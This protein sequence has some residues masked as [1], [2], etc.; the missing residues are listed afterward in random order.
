MI[1]PW[2]PDLNWNTPAGE[3]LNALLHVLP[4]DQPIQITVFGSAPLQLGLDPHFLSVDVDLFSSA[5]LSELIARHHLGKGQRDVYIEECAPSIFRAGPDWTTR[6]FSLRRGPVT[7]HFP[8]PIDI[9]VSKLGRFEPKDV[10]AATLLQ[11]HSLVPSEAALKQVLMNAVDIYKPPFAEEQV[12]GDPIL[13]TTL[14]WQKLYGHAIDVRREIITP[15]LQ[16]RRR[17]QTFPP[18][19]SELKEAAETSD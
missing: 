9:V 15:A 7:L 2:Q 6:A 17:Y 8:H 13:N 16:S 3:A 14:L 18:H 11:T 12:A 10:R 5:D 4:Q 19:R 1:A